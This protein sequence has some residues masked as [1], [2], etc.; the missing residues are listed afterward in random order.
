MMPPDITTTD[1]VN[2]LGMRFV[3]SLT[4]DVLR[5]E[6]ARKIRIAAARGMSGEAERLREW[7]CCQLNVD[8]GAVLSPRKPQPVADA[9]AVAMWVV[10]ESLGTS[11]TETA[12]IFDKSDH[13]TVSHAIGRVNR[14]PRLLSRAQEL[15]RTWRV[16]SIAHQAQS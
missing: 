14:T 4:I 11:R 13:S 15:A 2:E 10:T 9:R 3:R 1:L 7:V 12:R 8:E 6:L 16:A 5:S